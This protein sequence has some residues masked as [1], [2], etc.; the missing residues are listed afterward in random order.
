MDENSESK[1]LT[2]TVTLTSPFDDFKRGLL[3]SKVYLSN[4]AYIRGVADLDFDHKKFTTSVEGNRK[5]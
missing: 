1:N 4:R 2:G 3:L 5:L